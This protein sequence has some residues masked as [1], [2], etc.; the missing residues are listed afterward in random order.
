MSGRYLAVCLLLSFYLK[1]KNEISKAIIKNSKSEIYI[2][3][4]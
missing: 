4:T 1:C 2:L 3:L